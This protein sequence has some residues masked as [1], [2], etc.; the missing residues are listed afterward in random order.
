MVVNATGSN[1]QPPEFSGEVATATCACGYPLF[2]GQG[3]PECGLPF[4][5]ATRR[6]PPPITWLAAI[7]IALADAYW[8]PSMRCKCGWATHEALWV[9]GVSAAA[10]WLIFLFA[11]PPSWPLRV[12]V[13][14]TAVATSLLVIRPL[15][16]VL[17]RGH[18]PLLGPW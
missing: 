13:M 7:P 15:A 12:V 1:L 18:D 10:V 5:E 17:W 3:C 11:R 4:A 14:A 2:D 6:R 8:L 9:A 16:D